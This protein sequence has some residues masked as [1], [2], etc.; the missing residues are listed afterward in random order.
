[1]QQSSSCRASYTDLTCPEE[2]WQIMEHNSKGQSLLDLAWSL[3]FNINHHLRRTHK[4]MSRL[5]ESMDLSYREWR[6]ECSM[7]WKQET[8]IG[9][10]SCPQYYGPSGPM[11]TEQIEIHLSIWSMK[12]TRYYHPRYIYS[13]QGWHILIQNTR[14]Q[15]ESWIPSC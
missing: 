14:Q 11:W 15:L 6:L 13:Q 9:I 10:R 12:Q 1:M 7:I 4:Q 3:T 2:F 5:N 8:K